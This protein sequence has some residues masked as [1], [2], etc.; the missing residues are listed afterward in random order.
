MKALTKKLLFTFLFTLP[1]FIQ[2]ALPDPPG[3]P[4]PGGDPGGSGGVPVG[5]PID[6]TTVVLLILAFCYGVYKLV[7]FR[8]NK[9]LEGMKQS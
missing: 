2:V 6:S 7:E 9:A 1:M 8:R 5:S 3:P 4:G